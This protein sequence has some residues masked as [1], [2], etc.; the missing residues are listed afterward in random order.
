MNPFVLRAGAWA[1]PWRLWTCHAVHFDAVHAG[2]NL[3]ALAVP[4][5]LVRDRGR[6]ARGLL[7]AAP[8]LALLLLPAIGPGTYRGASGLACTAW[9]A[10]GLGLLGDRRRRGEG[11]ALCGLLVGKLAW[12]AFRGAAWLP[13]GE[14]WTALPAAHLWGAALGGLLAGVDRFR[15]R[16]GVLDRSNN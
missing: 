1:E 2:L 9:A 3:A 10:A 4:F 14:G 12:E 8:V 15:R 11:L 5:L 13:G 6:L 16:G 7:V